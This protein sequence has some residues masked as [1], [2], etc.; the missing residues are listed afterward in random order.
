M[1]TEFPV[2]D[3][4]QRKCL[5][6]HLQKLQAWAKQCPQNFG[7]KYL[8]A[9]AEMAR[10]ESKHETAASF[11]DQAIDAALRNGFI[12]HQALGCEYAAR[13]Y[14]QCGKNEIAKPYLKKAYYLYAKWG[15]HA[16]V[17]HLEKN[18]PVC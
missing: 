16:K 2:R 15:A 14:L 1:E 3:R 9:A 17:S 12:H 5:R 4:K 13:F 8:L 10:A 6:A 7:H 11:Y 18:I